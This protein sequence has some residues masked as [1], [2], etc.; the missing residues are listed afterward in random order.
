MTIKAET[1]VISD[2]H[3]GSSHNNKEAF[4]S[5]LKEIE[6]NKLIIN[7]DFVDGWRIKRK[8]LNGLS[9]IDLKIF[10]KLIKLSKKISITWIAGNHDEFIE[11]FTPE[12]IGNICITK[13][14]IIHN[15]LILHGHQF[16]LF[17]LCGSQKI[18]KLGSIGYE[19]LLYLNKITSKIFKF[20]VSKKIKYN[21]KRVTSYINAFEE[22]ALSYMETE[23]C[24]M[25]ICGHIHTPTSHWPY[26]NC[27]DW[28]ENKTYMTYD[29]EEGWKI[30]EYKKEG[31]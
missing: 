18:A 14:T 16:D 10:S 30:Y 5:F 24:K 6:C 23:G 2:V 4:L 8:G 26:Y 21:I 25:V 20:S 3:L 19:F 28:Q 17:T 31:L 12:I 13:K 29:R 1:I 15:T 22:A 11:E 9:N 7:G 27:G